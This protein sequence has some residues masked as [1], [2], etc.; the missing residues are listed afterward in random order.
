MTT[1]SGQSSP[2][3]AD[4]EVEN[5]ML[6]QEIPDFESCQPPFVSPTSSKSSHST[7]DQI[8]RLSA[9]GQDGSR[10]SAFSPYKVSQDVIFL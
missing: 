1:K 7:P 6:K 4:K 2:T 10:K 8:V 3:I 9:L 5:V